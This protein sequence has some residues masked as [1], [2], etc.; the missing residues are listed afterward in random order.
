MVTIK[1]FRAARA[2]LGWSQTKLGEH[3]DLSLTTVKRMET[4]RGANVSDEAWAAAK[5]ALEAAGIEFTNGDAPGVKL[6]RRG[7]SKG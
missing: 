1:Q 6:K 7:K 3:A 4:G 2:L 5:A